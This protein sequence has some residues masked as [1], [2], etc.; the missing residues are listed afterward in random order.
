MKTDALIRIGSHDNT[1]GQLEWEEERVG[2][3]EGKNQRI[4]S[5]LC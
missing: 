1:P 4:R 5:A 3:L 2:K